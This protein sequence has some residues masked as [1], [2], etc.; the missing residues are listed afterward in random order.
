M[1]KN[2]VIFWGSSKIGSLYRTIERIGTL[3]LKWGFT[4]G[5]S[6]IIV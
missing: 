2:F 4:A 6:S 1:E 3:L 5:A